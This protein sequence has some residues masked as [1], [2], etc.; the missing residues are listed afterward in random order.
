MNTVVA[1]SCCCFDLLRRFHMGV[2]AN[3]CLG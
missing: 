1:H 2:Y 3:V